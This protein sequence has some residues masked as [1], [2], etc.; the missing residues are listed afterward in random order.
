MAALLPHGSWPRQ[1]CRAG[2]CVRKAVPLP[3]CRALLAAAVEQAGG[4]V[5]DPAVLAPLVQSREQAVQLAARMRSSC[6]ASPGASLCVPLFATSAVTG[7]SLQL[8]HAFLHALQPRASDSSADS[9]QGWRCGAVAASAAAD[10]E[11]RRAAA[12]APTH[13][14]IDATF[15]VADVGTGKPRCNCVMHLVLPPADCNRSVACSQPSK[16]NLACSRFQA[17]QSLFSDSPAAI[18]LGSLQWS[19]GPSCRAA[20]VWAASCCWG[21]WRAA[22]SGWCKSTASTTPRCPSSWHGRGS[23]SRWQYSRWMRRVRR[24]LR[25]QAQQRPAWRHSRAQTRP[26]GRTAPAACMPG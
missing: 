13:F 2:L 23:T 11:P 20:S 6:I 18:S 24:K 15:E 25:V 26:R 10:A 17:V 12:Q 16:A 5:D 7:A 3:A 9:M 19:A 4:A 22:A 1:P 14:H 8:L 21:R